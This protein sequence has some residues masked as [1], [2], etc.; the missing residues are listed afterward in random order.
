M[1]DDERAVR[2]LV[3]TW[4]KASEAGD[5]ETMRS[6]MADEVIFTVP[7]REQAIR[8]WTRCAATSATRSCSRITPVQGC[9]DR[10]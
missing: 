4:M 8:A 9:F 1:T 3:A 10:G 7:G 5:V 6:L 2:D